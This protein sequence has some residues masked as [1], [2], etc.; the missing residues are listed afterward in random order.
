MIFWTLLNVLLSSLRELFS[1][2]T[3]L[4]NSTAESTTDM[5]S[6]QASLGQRQRIMT[7]MLPRL[8]D[9][10]YESGY[11]CTLGD[12]YRD[13]RSHGEQGLEGPY[14]RPKSAHKYRLAI[15]LN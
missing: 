4:T 11:E 10:I 8:I 13:P 9:F 15:D 5:P 7:R 14:G 6:N 12:A 2:G 1:S 3:P